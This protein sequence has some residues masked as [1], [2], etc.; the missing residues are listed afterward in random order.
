MLAALCVLSAIILIESRAASRDRGNLTA[1]RAA[2]VV[3]TQFTWLF[4]ASAQTLRHIETSL[5]T[6]GTDARDTSIRSLSDA[7]RDLP[8]G[9]NY[10]VYDGNGRLTH[11]SLPKPRPIT[12]SD[13]DYFRRAKSGEELILSPMI[14]DRQSNQRSLIVARRIDAPSGFAGVVTIAIPIAK[15]ESLADAIG[16]QGD[17]TLALVHL[18]GMLLARAPPA[19]PMDLSDTEIFAQLAR[20]PDG[21]FQMDSPADGVTRIVGYWKLTNWPVIATAGIDSATVY[22]DFRDTLRIASALALPALFALGWLLQSL[23]RLMQQDEARRV[24]L[25]TANRRATFLLREVHHRLKNNLQ[26]VASLIRLEPALPDRQKQSLLGRL[27]AMVSAHEAMYRSDQFE[28]ICVGPYL[29]RLI[30]DIARG[31][32]GNVDLSLDIA[33]IRLPGDRA[34]LLG[35]LVNELVSNA[36]KHAFQRRG[37]G[38]LAVTLATT[39]SGDMRLVVADDGPGYCPDYQAQGMG[40]RLIE[41]FAAQLGGAVSIDG[42]GCTT[43]TVQ[44]PLNW[45]ADSEPAHSLAGQT[46]SATGARSRAAIRSSNPARSSSR[47]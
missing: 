24:E 29:E 45:L 18:D 27:T 35:L 42:Q 3:A 34:M 31:H 1:H 11:S 28:E 5:A 16:L 15:L 23:L 17:S 43:V 40:S 39:P 22:A 10:S 2:H 12:V 25:E 6:Q 44:F 46:V 20:S 38:R 37:H 21:F 41:A 4:E 14:V 47:T 19:P 32:G 13:R 36:W 30:D 8:A 7:V 26:T 33:H 9:L